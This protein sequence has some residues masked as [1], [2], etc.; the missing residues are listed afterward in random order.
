MSALLSSLNI[1]DFSTL[2]PGPFASKTLADLGAEVLRVES[3]KHPDFTRSLPSNSKGGLNAHASLNRSKQSIGLNLKQ[4]DA[5]K[6]VK[7]LVNKY[8]IVLEQFRPG[9]MKRLG[10]DY[11]ELRKYNQ[12]LIFCSLTG[13]GQTGPYRNRAG[14]QVADIAGGAY[15]VVIGILAAV[16]HRQLTGEGQYIDISMTDAMFSMNVFEGSNWLSGGSGAEPESTMLNGGTLYDY[17]KTQ[18]GRWVS[19]SSLE[20]LFLN[21]LIKALEL[22]ENLLNT[23][24]D[25]QDA[26]KKLKE[27]L[28]KRF[29]ERPWSEWETVFANCD[30]CVELVLEFPEAMQHQQFKAREM[31][32]DIPDSSGSTQKQIAS[33]F[34]FSS[35]KP[36]YRHA[37]VEL[38]EQTD[39]VL[40]ELGYTQ[41]QINKLKKAGVCE[42]NKTG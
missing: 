30:A 1:L 25:D 33:P 4:A 18:D 5:V 31:I 16:I 14:I 6:I 21:A 2:L 36:E 20:P 7:K 24:L 19:V 39:L 15:H 38:G 37:G 10:L 26:Q 32:V 41:K 12:S 9:V 8:D 28:K 40:K 13:Y 3:T 34:K 42:D 22:P 27:I 35:C 29:L 23:S 17:Y 11:Q